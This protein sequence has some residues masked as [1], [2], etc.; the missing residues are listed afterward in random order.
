LTIFGR[1]LREKNR[2]IARAVQ[3][4]DVAAASLANQAAADP[5]GID[6]EATRLA[7]EASIH[8]E[9]VRQ[10]QEAEA[11]VQERKEQSILAALVFGCSC[12]GRVQDLY[13]FAETFGLTPPP[14]TVALAGW[15]RTHAHCARLGAMVR[16]D[17]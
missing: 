11:L 9:R 12:G 5:L 8:A 10:R 16:E 4:D 6:L 17:A 3:G 7:L 13:G 1:W 14:H 15:L 2:R